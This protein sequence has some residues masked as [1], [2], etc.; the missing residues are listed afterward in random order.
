MTTATRYSPTA[1]EIAEYA[2]AVAATLPGVW[3]MPDGQETHWGAHITRAD[4]LRLFLAFQTYGAKLGRVEITASTTTAHPGPG[5]MD[6][7]A[8][9]TPNPAPTFAALGDKGQTP[10]A[11]AAAIARRVLTDEMEAKLTAARETA[12]D[13]ANA[14]ARFRRDCETLAEP[15]GDLIQITPDHNE[16]HNKARV[17]IETPG[18]SL[19]GY[20]YRDVDQLARV[21]LERG[22]HIDRAALLH[23]LA[24]FSAYHKAAKARA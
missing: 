22:G 21:Y 8:R 16:P 4:G 3:T 15:W 23:M 9:L 20:A 14:C 10:A 1:A 7:I 13:L 2:R 12:Q 18:L 24:A 17:R 19:T 6:R 11:C 5:H